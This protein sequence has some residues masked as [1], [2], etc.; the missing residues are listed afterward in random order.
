MNFEEM[1]NGWQTPTPLNTVLSAS[2]LPP[3]LLRAVPMPSTGLSYYQI[4][5]V[6]QAG[7]ISSPL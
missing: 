6:T 1:Q 7:M 3:G 2:S 4:P 5:G